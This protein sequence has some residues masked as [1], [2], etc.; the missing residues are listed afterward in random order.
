[1]SGPEGPGGPGAVPCPHCGAGQDGRNQFCPQ[2]GGPVLCP[3]GHPVLDAGQR[4]CLVCGVPLDG[5]KELAGSR[6]RNWRPLVLAGIAGA[7]VLALAGCFV[8]GRHDDEGSTR[9]STA[10]TTATP[11]KAG[12]LQPSGSP[13]TA[14]TTPTAAASAATVVPTLAGQGAVPAATTAPAFPQPT[15]TPPPPPAASPTPVPATVPP[16]P[17]PA[18]RSVPVANAMTSA[19]LA[20]GAV[21]DTATVR[22]QIDPAKTSW[23]AWNNTPGVSVQRPERPGAVLFGPG[24]Y[25]TDDHIELT[26]RAPGG[27]TSTAIL[28]R[29][30]AFGRSSGPQNVIFGTAAAAPD[31]F[32]ISPPFATPPSEVLIFDEGG[33][34][35]AVFT[36]AGEYEFTFKFINAFT[37]DGGHAAIYLLVFGTP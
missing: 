15:A 20:P 5:Q 14:N 21:Y 31:V 32:R 16:T 37:G 10:R 36:S 4:F 33:T 7:A 18:V 27:A 23:V 8:F 19:G 17:V 22:I 29:N 35:N 12:S 34:H 24:G 26:V 1:M 13:G 2:C 11:T 30:D 25:G 9:A 6:E 28:D 3:A